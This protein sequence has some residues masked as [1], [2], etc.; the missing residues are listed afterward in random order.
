MSFQT[1]EDDY[2]VTVV[3]LIVAAVAAGIYL[4]YTF[5]QNEVNGGASQDP[6][7]GESNGFL[8]NLDADI[9]PTSN[10]GGG[11][12]SGSSETYSGAVSTIFSDPIASFKSL[13]GIN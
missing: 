5:Y 4:L 9:F 8:D 13:L 3:A 10:P 1:I 6:T 11:E 7:T 2:G 12:V